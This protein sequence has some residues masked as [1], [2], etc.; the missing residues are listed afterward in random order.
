[1]H[2]SDSSIFF[3]GSHLRLAV[4]CTAG[5]MAAMVTLHAYAQ[6]LPLPTLDKPATQASTGGTWQ[7]LTKSQKAALAP[8][9]KSW[10]TLNEGQQR[11]WLALAKTY[12]D[13]GSS[14]QEK[15]HSRMTEWANLPTKD[16]EAARLNFAQ[17]KAVTKSDRAANWEAYQA[18]SPDERKQLAQRAKSKPT[19]AAV[20]VK[21]V[22]QDKLT[23][24]PVTRHTPTQERAAAVMQRPINRNTLLPQTPGAAF[25]G[26]SLAPPTK[27]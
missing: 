3:A 12:P 7:S 24:V 2:F 23:A 5:L 22:A 14:E 21:P 6:A 16:R 27:P 18:L 4:A 13:L 1:M 15:L 26:S 11:K 19:G 25:S 20:A 10:D 17:S 9:G 8:L